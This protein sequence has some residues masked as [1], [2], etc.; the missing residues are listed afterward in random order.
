MAVASLQ[1]A[2]KMGDGR[3]DAHAFLL[4]MRALSLSNT[5]GRR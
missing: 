5:F 1:T 3:R 4:G 2:H